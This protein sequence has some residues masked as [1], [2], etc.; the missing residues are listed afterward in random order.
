MTELINRIFEL[1]LVTRHLTD[2]HWNYFR[3]FRL[4]HRHM[5]Q[6]F[7]YF[8]KQR[9]HWNWESNCQVVLPQNTVSKWRIFR[10]NVGYFLFGPTVN[11]F[12][13]CCSIFKTKVR[14]RKIR[15]LWK[16]VP[17][18]TKEMS[19]I[20][21]CIYGPELYR[22]YRLGTRVTSKVSKS[23]VLFFNVIPSRF[24]YWKLGGSVH[25]KCAGT[26]LFDPHEFNSSR[27]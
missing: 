8:R 21:K 17:K 24:L 1:S 27:H 7:Q 15:F 18:I 20:F 9:K 6:Y 16:K 4:S 5:A 11:N 22:I 2:L 25:G 10:H 19:V 13:S 23:F 3:V 12:D 14:K 26:V